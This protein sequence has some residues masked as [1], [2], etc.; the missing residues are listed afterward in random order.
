MELAI[1]SLG[2]GK[3]VAA[4]AGRAESLARQENYRQSFDLA[5]ARAVGSFELV[6]EL[7]LPFLATGGE[8][9]VQKS[10]GQLEHDLR[11]ALVVLPKLGGQILETTVLDKRILGKERA[12]IVIE[13]CVPSTEEFPR[14]WA[15]MKSSPLSGK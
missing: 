5:T 4:V 7:T 8:L 13:K 9:F 12:I 1:E 10:T 3:Q 14:A 2:L 15:R 6:A 11:T